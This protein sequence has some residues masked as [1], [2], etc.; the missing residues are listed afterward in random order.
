M[1][2]LEEKARN[3]ELEAE[4]ILMMEQQKAEAQAK[5]FHLQREV[6]KAKAR[7]LYV[8][9]TKDDETKTDI[10]EAEV[11]DEV[12]LSRHQGNIKHSQPQS[13]LEVTDASQ[14]NDKEDDRVKKSTKKNNSTYY[15]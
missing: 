4:A 15:K 11:K 13:C 1:K 7:A 10:V 5:M 12:I 9:Y 14:S 2:L 8:G 3:V 6:A